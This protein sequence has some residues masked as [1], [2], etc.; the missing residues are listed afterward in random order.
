MVEKIPVIDLFAGAGGLSEGFAMFKPPGCNYYPF[1]IMLSVDMAECACRTL[2]LRSFYHQFLG[3]AVP[4]EY[5]QYIQEA[6]H[7]RRAIESEI[8]RVR[9]FSKY[10]Y[11]GNVARNEVRKARLGDPE[12][13]RVTYTRIRSILREH[14]G[15][16]WVLMGGPPCQAYSLIGRG[17]RQAASD[18]R[19]EYEKD[20]RLFLYREYQRVI[21]EFRPPVFIMENVEG[22]TSSRVGG[23]NIFERMLTG[24]RNPSIIHTKGNDTLRNSLD[25]QNDKR[26]EYVVYSLT[27]QI[28]NPDHLKPE[29][30]IVRS[31]DYGIPQARHRIILLGVRSDI[32][33][34]P[35]TLQK[36]DATVPTSSVLS[37]LPPIRSMLSGKGNV[38]GDWHDA[39]HA[40][41]SD[42]RFN[43]L[44]FPEHI[45]LDRRISIEK[46]IMH[47]VNRG[48]KGLGI[49]SEFLWCRSIPEY[50]PDWYHDPDL[51]G[52]CNHSARAHMPMDIY[53]Y[54]YA[55]CFAKVCGYSPTLRDFP[56]WLWP[57]HKS[58]KCCCDN[59]MSYRKGIAFKDRFH[60][61]VA[62]KP[63]NTITSHMA[64]DGHYNIH[65]EPSQCRSLTV[66]EAA[67]LQTFPDN[68]FFEG[69]RTE[70][71]R[72]VGNAVPPL[73]AYQI[74]N[75]VYAIYSR[76]VE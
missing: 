62:D 40:I 17:R 3:R 70:Q 30:F 50:R 47:V 39:I 27:T 73:L 21:R 58:A 15:R 26:F 43:H 71:Y 57:E 49:G 12:D 55:S 32:N 29:D 13:D 41:C 25:E 60:V 7:R 23:D 1:K 44:C 54:L 4:I 2:E 8:A 59:K 65:Y 68:Y 64:K 76:L 18:G 22:I 69:S 24:L 45:T 75:V 61:R 48:S 42:K 35:Q 46:E 5:Y 66:R 37:D 33:I 6:G 34:R 74:A 72:Q 14:Q 11:E 20:E 10:P 19:S 51:G 31:E 67:R 63:A 52:V 16:F 9:L 28:D 53:R 38:Q 36:H 56:E